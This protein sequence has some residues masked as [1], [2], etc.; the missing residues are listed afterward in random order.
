MSGCA[1]VSLAL[2]GFL[3]RFRR[4]RDSASEPDGRE[5]RLEL[6]DAEGSGDPSPIARL[7]EAA[8]AGA[9]LITQRSVLI[10]G[11]LAHGI[12]ADTVALIMERVRDGVGL[13]ERQD[14]SLSSRIGGPPE[15]PPDTEWPRDVDGEPLTFIGRLALADLP[16]LEP[17]PGEGTL[18][19]FWSQRFF[20]FER[21]DF[22]AATRV[23]WVPPTEETVSAATPDGVTAY[24]AVPLAGVLMPILGEV[25]LIEVP[26]AEEEAFYNVQDALM[27]AYDHQLLGASRDVQGPVLSEVGYW[28]DQGFP[29]T[30]ADFNDAELAGEG[31]TLLAQIESTGELLFGDAGALYLVIPQHD[32]VARRF[33][34]VVGIMQCS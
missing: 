33:D 19:V 29:E 20:E 22:R 18:L 4:N 21:M 26:D 7:R 27:S 5:D 3:D 30:R 32:L 23:F 11:L 8:F 10:D 9:D 17:L 12:S 28:F 34:R 2:V 13:L 31:W 16:R 6:H 14:G 1:H 24:D 25:D 15:L